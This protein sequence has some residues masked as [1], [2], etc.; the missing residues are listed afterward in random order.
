MKGGSLTIKIRKKNAQGRSIEST[1][2]DRVDIIYILEMLR[3]R[4]RIILPEFL[5]EKFLEESYG[6]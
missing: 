5:E 6:K 2:F 4:R 1:P 3:S